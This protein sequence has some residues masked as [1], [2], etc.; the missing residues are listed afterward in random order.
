MILED[1]AFSPSNDLAPPPPPTLLSRQKVVSLFQSSC[2]SP[3]ELTG[4]L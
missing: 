4:R 2:V 3:V 1:H